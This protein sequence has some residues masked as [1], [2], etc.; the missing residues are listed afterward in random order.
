MQSKKKLGLLNQTSQEILINSLTINSIQQINF[1]V[2]LPL[3]KQENSS[4]PSYNNKN[5]YQTSYNR[6]PLVCFYCGKSNHHIKDCR[7][8]IYDE[9]NGKK[10]SNSY[11]NSFSKEL[12]YAIAYNI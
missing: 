2:V 10:R 6:K 8:W 5:T 11:T 7:K 4:K 1:K 3:I 12:I 9:N